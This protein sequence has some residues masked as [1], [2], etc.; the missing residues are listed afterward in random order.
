MFYVYND[1][2]YDVLDI[3]LGIAHRQRAHKGV[4]TT[5]IWKA[6]DLVSTGNWSWFISREYSD[7]DYGAMSYYPTN[8]TVYV[9]K[10]KV[11]SKDQVFDTTTVADDFEYTIGETTFIGKGLVGNGGYMST[12][13]GFNDSSFS[14]PY[15]VNGELRFFA[16]PSSNN[17]EFKPLFGGQFKET[18]KVDGCYVYVTIKGAVEGQVFMQ[19]F[20]SKLLNDGGHIG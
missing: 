13:G 20:N 1:T 19:I 2:D 3:S 16:R 11:Y 15:Y 12:D 8:G 7:V 4:W 18:Y 14:N 17:E 10:A 6:E 9:S 5:V